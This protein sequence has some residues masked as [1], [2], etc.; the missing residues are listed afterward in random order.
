MPEVCRSGLLLE[1][2]AFGAPEGFHAFVLSP[3][4]QAVFDH[5]IAAHVRRIGGLPVKPRPKKE[6]QPRCL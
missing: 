5:I 1:C 6:T 4:A 3:E 2:E